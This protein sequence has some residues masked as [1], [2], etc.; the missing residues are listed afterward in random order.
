[1]NLLRMCGF[2]AGD[3]PDTDNDTVG[4]NV[5]GLTSLVRLMFR[6]T[7][8]LRLDRLRASNLR[9]VMVKIRPEMKVCDKSNVMA[10]TSLVW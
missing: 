9:D 3:K 7:D 5:G 4:K 2:S 6:L 8:E 10:R 1:M